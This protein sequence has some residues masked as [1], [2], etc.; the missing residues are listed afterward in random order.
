MNTLRW[1]LKQERGIRIIEPNENISKEYLSAAKNDFKMMLKSDKKWSTIQAYYCCY[2]SLYS[3]LAKCGIKCEIH[4][5]SL[6]IMP[7]LGYN[8]RFCRFIKE[9]K[10]ERIDVQYYL[11]KAEKVDFERVKEFLEV[12]EKRLIEINDIE[13]QEIRKKIKENE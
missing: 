7:F 9:L 10:E 5:C 12:S 11:K 8:K 3:I 6:K 13:I 1:C 4:E 2:N